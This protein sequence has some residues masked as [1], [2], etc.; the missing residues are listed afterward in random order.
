MTPRTDLGFI[1]QVLDDTEATSAYAAGRKHGVNSTTIRRWQLRQM[2]EPTGW[3]T[4]ADIAA[5]RADH[6]QHAAQRARRA[7]QV[8]SYRARRYLARGPLWL[9]AHGTERRLRALCAIGWTC[10]DLA[11]RLGVSAARVSQLTAGR[12][13]LVR[14]ETHAVV[15]ALYAALS[16]TVP[17][18]HLGWVLARTRRQAAAKG[19]APPLAWDDHALD[20]PDGRP[21]LPRQR[22][23]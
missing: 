23:A 20:D 9:P 7:R 2:L 4:T 22:A 1:R 18:H 15:V 3:P 10:G 12:A 13:T 5:W 21:H 11:P 17:D 14:R 8:A 6:E 19:W 16:M